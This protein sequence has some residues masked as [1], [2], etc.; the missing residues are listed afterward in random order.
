MSRDTITIEH[1]DDD[2]DFP[3]PS[4]EE[5]G[6]APLQAENG[7]TPAEY[8]LEAVRRAED[9]SSIAVLAYLITGGAILAA[10]E[11]QSR[12]NQKRSQMQR[13]QQEAV[14]LTHPDDDRDQLRYALIGLMLQTPASLQRGLSTLERMASGLVEFISSG[15]RPV[16]N[17]R[18]ARPIQVRYESLVE[19]GEQI[20]AGWID[21][22]RSGELAS[23]DMVQDTADE[24]INELILVLANRPELRE[25]VQ[26]QSIGMAQEFSGALQSRAA[27]ADSLLERVAYRVLPFARRDTT[28]TLEVPVL[29][30][31]EQ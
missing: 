2:Y 6:L 20:V 1:I 13:S 17:S 8:P 16:S 27:A 28:P 14:L 18:L 11:I 30:E 3:D 15:L 12:I 5:L 4:D 24:A 29:P 25:L 19:R 31:D 22:G 9:D 10:D 23:R 26:Q 7:E 21:A